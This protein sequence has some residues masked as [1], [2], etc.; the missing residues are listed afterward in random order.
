M[1]SPAKLSEPPYVVVIFTNTRTGVDDEAYYEMAE[2]MEELAAEQDGFLG[3]ESARAEDGLSITLSYWRDEDAVVA[4]KADVEHLAA[5]RL[6]RE[7][8]YQEFA[9][10]VATVDRAYGFER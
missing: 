7:K 9:L 5:Q 10:R 4:W 1:S 2:R 8:W 3:V 6:G